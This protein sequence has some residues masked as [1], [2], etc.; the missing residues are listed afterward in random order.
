MLTTKTI[1][2]L[3]GFC[4]CFFLFLSLSSFAAFAAVS[5]IL[6]TTKHQTRTGFP[7]P[8]PLA[9]GNHVVPNITIR[10]ARARSF[11]VF[12]R[13]VPVL[14]F[15]RLL[16]LKSCSPKLWH[17]GRYLTIL[18]CH[19]FVFFCCLCSFV[20]S[21]VVLCLFSLLSTRIVHTR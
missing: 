3:F 16:S 21:C 10:H 6:F 18:V 4:F 5:L 8:T 7:C 15:E 1:S 2:V 19:V 20:C 12:L 9:Q 11:C 14:I 17:S 13:S